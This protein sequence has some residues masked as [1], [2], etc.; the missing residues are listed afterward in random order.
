MK[1]KKN[2]CSVYRFPR[3]IIR[4]APLERVE[5]NLL[6]R[7]CREHNSVC[8]SCAWNIAYRCHTLAQLNSGPEYTRQSGAR[9]VSGGHRN[10]AAS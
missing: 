4:R 2:R 1:P 10:P 9:P 5:S 7:P 8:R 3:E 6:G